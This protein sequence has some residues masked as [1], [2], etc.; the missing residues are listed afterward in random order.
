M[1]P[2]IPELVVELIPIAQ[3]LESLSVGSFDC[4][5]FVCLLGICRVLSADVDFRC[6][7]ELKEINRQERKMQYRIIFTNRV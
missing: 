5:L 2:I 3:V 1:P 7:H 4:L 6:A